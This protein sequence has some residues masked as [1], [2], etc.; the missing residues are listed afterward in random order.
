MG[1]PDTAL[2]NLQQAIN[3]APDKYRE[4]A[5]TDTDFDSLRDD[6][7]FQALISSPELD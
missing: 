4:L 6:P 3:L 2:E 1:N 7:R 5:T